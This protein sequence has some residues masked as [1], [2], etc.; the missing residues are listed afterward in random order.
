MLYIVELIE[1]VIYKAV[2]GV[3]GHQKYNAP[4]CLY[5]AERAVM[6]LYLVRPPLDLS[7]LFS[8]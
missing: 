3:T 8:V 6:L 4:I 7:V 1:P 5:V 2:S